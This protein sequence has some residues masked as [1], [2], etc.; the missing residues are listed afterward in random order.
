[1]TTAGSVTFTCAVAAVDL[2]A[3]DERLV[4][5]ALDRAGERRLRP[6][7]VLGEHL[8]DLVRLALG[9]LVAEEH[10]VRLLLVDER[11]EAARDEVA[12]ERVVGRVDADGAVGARRRAS[13]RS[14]CSASFGPNVTTTTS[15]RRAF[16]FAPF[17]VR[18]SAVSRA[19]SSNGFGFGSRPVVSIL[20]W[21]ES[22]ILLGCPGRRPA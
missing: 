18:R 20:P 4:V 15:P 19:Y 1:M 3:D 10:E 21:G 16:V 17:S 8:P 22:L 11:L 2:A 5:L 12:V 7:E 14:I 6:A 13:A 9:L